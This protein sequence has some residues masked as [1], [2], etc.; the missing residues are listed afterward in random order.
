MH[1]SFPANSH[2]ERLW[3]ASRHWPYQHFDDNVGG[4]HG[5]SIC[6]QPALRNCRETETCVDRR[7]LL[8]GLENGGPAGLIYGYLFVWVGATLQ[9]CVMGEMASM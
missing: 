4:D 6:T 2:T 9:A 3:A 7:T 1:W 8:N 5:V